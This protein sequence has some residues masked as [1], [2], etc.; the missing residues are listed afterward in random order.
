MFQNFSD[1]KRMLGKNNTNKD[2]NLVETDIDGPGRNPK[3]SNKAT[4]TTKYEFLNNIFKS[5]ILS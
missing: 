1:G 2:E 5:K 4:I 3:N